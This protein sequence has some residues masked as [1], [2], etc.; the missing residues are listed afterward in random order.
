VFV[1]VCW[2]SISDASFNPFEDCGQYSQI[3]PNG[4]ADGA[5]H[6]AFE[7][8][9]GQDPA[10]ENWGCYAEGDT[11][12]PGV[13]K[14]TTCYVRV[15]DTV[16]SNFDNDAE[17]PFTFVGSDRVDPGSTAGGGDPAEAPRLPTV[18]GAVVPPSA[19]AAPTGE[20]GPGESLQVAGAAGVAGVSLAG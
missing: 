16:V 6:A 2:K 19:V 12:P 10:G 13:W 20:P 18:T 14:H 17:V 15:T 3:T 7:V 9:R 8:F 4:T 5:G 11:E 1:D